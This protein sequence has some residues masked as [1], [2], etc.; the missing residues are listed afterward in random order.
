MAAANKT[1]YIVFDCDTNEWT[2]TESLDMLKADLTER[3][4]NWDMYADGTTSEDMELIIIKI[5]PNQKATEIT[6]TMK[7][8]RKWEVNE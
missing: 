3:A 6:L 1:K 2:Q 7:V 8:E 4:R 5:P